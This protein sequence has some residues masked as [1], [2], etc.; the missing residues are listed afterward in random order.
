MELVFLVGLIV[1]AV[2][3]LARLF[4]T[5]RAW[6][7]AFE[8]VASRFAGWYIPARLIRLPAAAFIYRDM[9]CRVRC[10]R[11][12]FWSP[13]RRTEFRIAW[14]GRRDLLEIRRQDLP[15]QVGRGGL[16]PVAT[17]HP[18]TGNL[19]AFGTD[20]AVARRLITASV[21]WQAAELASLPPAADCWITL[22]RGWLTITRDGWLT[23]AG[24][25]DEFVRHS[26]GLFD[27]LMLTISEGIE[28]QEGTIAAVEQIRC[29]VCSGDILGQMVICVRCKTPHCDDCWQYNGK[30]GMY[31]CDET[32][33][34]MV[35][36]QRA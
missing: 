13:R 36:R 34:T 15:P 22:H 2:V 18:L 1:V 9:S 12:W 29:P 28:F 26:L 7:A 24:K 8:R 14:P 3:V 32:R 35:G 23:D 25:L 20:P 17:G 30:C 16:E 27:Q 21:A 33:F 6:T 11:N 4:T 5:R 10:A 19:A 31:A